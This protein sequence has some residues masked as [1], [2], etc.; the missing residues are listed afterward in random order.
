MP[1]RP[2]SEKVAADP[3][4][5]PRQ[6]VSTS[7]ARAPLKITLGIALAQGA[8]LYLLTLAQINGAWP[9]G[10]PVWNLPLWTLAV[11]WP[12]LLHL[13]IDAANARRTIAGASLFASM[14]VAVAV[15][16]G[17]QMSPRGAFPS[18]S[19]GAVFLNTSTVPRYE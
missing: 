18:E 11:A 19:S 4:R 8:A 15:Y 17:W 10:D 14:L 1:P 5:P 12:V 9:S 13:S 7:T 16:T 3:S 6:L 2:R